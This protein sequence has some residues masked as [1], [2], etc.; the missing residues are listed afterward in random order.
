[1]RWVAKAHFGSE[2]WE[3]HDFVLTTGPRWLCDW[4]ARRWLRRHPYS[5]VRIEPLP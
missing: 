2:F 1:M 3:G 5:Y 4:R